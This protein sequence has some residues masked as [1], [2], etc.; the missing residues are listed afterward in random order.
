MVA[1]N[2]AETRLN[3]VKGQ[4]HSKLQSAT[5][6]RNVAKQCHDLFLD[7]IQS[8]TTRELTITENISKLRAEI[9]MNEQDLMAAQQM[10]SQTKLRV[11][12]I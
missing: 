6:R 5:R 2:K 8:N 12:M 9:S 3:F 4:E 1:L 7:A 10:E 11:E